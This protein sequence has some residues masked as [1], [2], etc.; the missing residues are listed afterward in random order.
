MIFLSFNPSKNSNKLF[1]TDGSSLFD[2]KTNNT[3]NINSKY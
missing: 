1:I 3:N 2:N